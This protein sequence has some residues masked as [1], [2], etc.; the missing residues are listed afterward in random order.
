MSEP[1]LIQYKYTPTQA[2]LDE[3][4]DAIRAAVARRVKIDAERITFRVTRVDAYK[5]PNEEPYFRM[6][7]GELL[8]DGRHINRDIKDE[9]Y[10]HWLC[11]QVGMAVRRTPDPA[12]LTVVN[13]IESKPT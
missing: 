2:E 13:R 6:D 1:R 11:A 3:L 5:W 9:R 10:L 4:S 8:L 7:A 12:R